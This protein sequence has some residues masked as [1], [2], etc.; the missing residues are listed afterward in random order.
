RACDV[1]SGTSFPP[2]DCVLPPT[3][4]PR[5][6]HSGG[7]RSPRHKSTS[8]QQKYVPDGVG[9]TPISASPTPTTDKGSDA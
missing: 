4:A 9:S 8:P 7:K 1:G 5:H 3:T 2:E 6:A